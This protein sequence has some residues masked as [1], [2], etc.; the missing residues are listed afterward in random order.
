VWYVHCF[1]RKR[2]DFLFAEGL[3]SFVSIH[4]PNVSFVTG[5]VLIGPKLVL[6]A[7]HCANAD[8]R[9]RV[10]AWE[11]V[12]DGYEVSITKKIVHEDYSSGG[13]DHDIVLFQIQDEAPHDYIRLKKEEVTGGQF[14]VIGFGDTD[15]GPGMS[16]SSELN[17]VEL[18]Y[19]DSDTCDRGHGGNGDVTDDMLCAIGSG[20]DSC[21]GDSGGP[22]FIRGST[23]ADDELVGL[24]SWGRGCALSGYAGGMILIV[25]QLSADLPYL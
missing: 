3:V 6:S 22:L 13:F 4:C 9:F 18:E 21:I 19:V 8:T 7:A 25:L 20:K 23:A 17:E 1:L 16:L 14:T 15:M 11:G 24:V 12:S 2:I 5:A 10:G